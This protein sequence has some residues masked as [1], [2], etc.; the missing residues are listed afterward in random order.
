MVP[1]DLSEVDGVK[2][3]SFLGISNSRK[4]RLC[5]KQQWE[6]V[7]R[8]YLWEVGMSVSGKELWIKAGKTSVL[9]RKK[10][11]CRQ[12]GKLKKKK[13]K[14]ILGTPE[15]SVVS[16]KLVW[17]LKWDLFLRCWKPA[18]CEMTAMMPALDIICNYSFLY[19]KAEICNVT[20][21][22]YLICR[23][24]RIIYTNN[25]KDFTNCCMLWCV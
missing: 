1:I 21:F 7:G 12:E 24:D 14:G 5:G 15:G 23:T 17:S 16:S 6:N 22:V 2:K 8:T 20:R 9:C 11:A 18:R 4:I 3:N 25:N 10:Y 19:W 13:K